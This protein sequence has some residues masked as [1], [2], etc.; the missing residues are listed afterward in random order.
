ML[1]LN[2]KY[3]GE[4]GGYLMKR[5]LVIFLNVMVLVLMLSACSGQDSEVVG[6]WED[7]FV[8]FVTFDFK[9]DG[10][11]VIDTGMSAVTGTWETSGDELEVEY[12]TGKTVTYT[13]EVNEN[14][15]SLTS[16]GETL[17]L[18]KK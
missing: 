17:K 16:E 5:N 4:W 14:T 1:L 2:V 18:N 6:T 9:A 7:G 13:Y 11:V 12:S 8:G 10:E 15:L 3:M